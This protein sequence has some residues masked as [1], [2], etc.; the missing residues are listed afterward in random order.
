MIDLLTF[1]T[2]AY[3]IVDQRNYLFGRKLE[4]QINL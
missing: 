4:K 3:Q 2:E 1:Q